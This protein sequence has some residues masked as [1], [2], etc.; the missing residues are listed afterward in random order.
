MLGHLLL[1]HHLAEGST[2]T[3]AVLADDPWWVKGRGSGT[4][5][6]ACVFIWVRWTN[7]R[8]VWGGSRPRA[9]MAGWLYFSEDG[10]RDERGMT[11]LVPRDALDDGTT[12][13]RRGRCDHARRVRPDRAPARPAS[14]VSRRHLSHAVRRNRWAGT[15][16]TR[17]SAD[18]VGARGGAR[19]RYSPTFL[20]RLAILLNLTRKETRGD[21]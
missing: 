7:G 5:R 18:A 4:M 11:R 10:A 21:L 19:P 8:R 6:S 12:R 16:K 15:L 20:V 14:R 17:W 1:L 2:V 13:S 9:L 3:G